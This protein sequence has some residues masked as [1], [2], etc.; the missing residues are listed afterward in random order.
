MNLSRVDRN[1]LTVVTIVTIVAVPLLWITS[2]GTQSGT[3][4]TVDTAVAATTTTLQLGLATDITADSPV[5]LEGPSVESPTGTGQIAYPANNDG[6]MRRGIATYKR[7]PDIVKTGCATN[8]A[9]L[10]SI[11]TVRN[12][13]NG[14]KVECTNLNIGYVPPNVDLV[15][16]TDL[17]EDVAEL[18]EAPL[19]VEM[20]W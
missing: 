14:R 4:T 3:E 5:N 10:G 6:Q 9:P 8:V 12:L 17:F 1:R 19:P 18:K 7:F 16:H 15:L 13:N 20:T 11:I 2:A